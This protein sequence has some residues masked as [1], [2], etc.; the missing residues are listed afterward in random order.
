MEPKYFEDENT[1]SGDIKIIFLIFEELSNT[2]I[3]KYVQVRSETSCSFAPKCSN[4]L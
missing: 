3:V 4:Q 2:K 1:N